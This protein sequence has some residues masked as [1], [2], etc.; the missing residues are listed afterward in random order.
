M[1]PE[2]SAQRDSRL[3]RQCPTLT[4]YFWSRGQRQPGRL[5]GSAAPT[6]RASRQRHPGEAAA[7]SAHLQGFWPRVPSADRVPALASR[8][9]PQSFLLPSAASDSPAGTS[10]ALA[11]SAQRSPFAEMWL[12]P[13]LEGWNQAPGRTCYLRLSLHAHGPS[14]RLSVPSPGSLLVSLTSASVCPSPSLFMILFLSVHSHYLIICPSVLIT[15]MSEPLHFP[16]GLA[17]VCLVC[18]SVPSALTR[19]A[20]PAEWP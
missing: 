12:E 4:R 17:S 5:M 19:C 6:R 1:F 15:P 8:G 7:G 9:G 13:P 14:I 2:G 11:C 18:L 16:S 20:I 10:K 3:P